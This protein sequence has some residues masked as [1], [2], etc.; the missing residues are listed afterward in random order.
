MPNPFDPTNI[1]V[2]Y[3]GIVQCAKNIVYDEKIRKKY[4]EK[5]NILKTDCINGIQ[6][7]IS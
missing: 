1:F 7:L 5:S 3:D 4:I 6:N 2:E